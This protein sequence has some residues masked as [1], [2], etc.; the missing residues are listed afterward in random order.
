MIYLILAQAARVAT[1]W[2]ADAMYRKILK[3][4]ALT[5]VGFYL[6]ERVQK[7]KMIDDI[8]RDRI[9]SK[10]GEITK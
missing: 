5:L 1:I 2:V 9:N 6:V 8:K 3:S 4:V 10:P 7:Q